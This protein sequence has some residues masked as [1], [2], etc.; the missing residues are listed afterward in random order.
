[1]SDD[2]VARGRQALSDYQWAKTCKVSAEPDRAYRLLAEALAEVERLR[3]LVNEMA[4][5]R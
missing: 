4:A 5:Q 1:M 2:V 3:E